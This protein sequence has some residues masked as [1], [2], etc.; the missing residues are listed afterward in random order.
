LGDI[1]EHVREAE[2][3][4]DRSILSFDSFAEQAKAFAGHMLKKEALAAYFETLVPN[5]QDGDPARAIATRETFQRLFESGKGND[6][7]TVRGTLWAALNGVVEY[8]DHE[9]QTRVREGENAVQNRFKSAQFGSGAVL[10]ERAW[11]QAL[12]L[13]G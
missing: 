13:L 7:P 11:S 2:R 1:Q 8:V 4:L 6:L 12:A 5:P 3:L 9:R 10:K